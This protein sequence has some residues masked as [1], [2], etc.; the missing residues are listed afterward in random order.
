MSRQRK[1]SSS[2]PARLPTHPEGGRRAP[3]ENGRNGAHDT[4]PPSPQVDVAALRALI[5]ETRRE[6]NERLDALQAALEHAA[7]AVGAAPGHVSTAVEVNTELPAA[8]RNG[9]GRPDPGVV[10]VGD[11]V[12]VPSLGGA[13]TVIE[14]A[15]SSH[16]FTVQ[17][18]RAR[19]RVR[20][21]DVWALDHGAA[22]PATP[23]PPPR[24]HLSAD[25]AEIDLHGFSERDALVTLELFLHHAFTQRTPRVRVIH[26]KGDGTLRAAVRRA[27][28]RSDLV[29]HIETGPHFQGDDGVTLA[30]L[31]V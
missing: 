12:Y 23:Q 28:A 18:G 9:A 7:P 21:D 24:R 4:A 26:G 29:R 11:E 3:T 25:I 16:T 20:R 5:E 2:R 8:H 31:D 1:G 30:E 27:L 13:Y 22:P 6:V 15:P 10:R 17:A 19:V 14:A